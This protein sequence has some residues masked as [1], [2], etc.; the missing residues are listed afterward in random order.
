MVG[1]KGLGE[2]GMLLPR[3]AGDEGAERGA[4]MAEDGLEGWMDFA[5]TSSCS[6]S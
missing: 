2:L 1:E 6:W 3:G 4:Q 5:G